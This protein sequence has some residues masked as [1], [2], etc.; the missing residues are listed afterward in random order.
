MPLIYDMTEWTE[1]LYLQHIA[2]P[3]PGLSV[4]YQIHCVGDA[5]PP[6]PHT[7]PNG[8][9]PDPDD[10]PEPGPWTALAISPGGLRDLGTVPTADEAIELCET[11]A[12]ELAHRAAETMRAAGGES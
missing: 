1:H 2:H 11:D 7:D 8:P 3:A 10:A 4:A 9:P 5:D 12:G 6:T